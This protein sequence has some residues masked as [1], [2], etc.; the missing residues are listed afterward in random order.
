MCKIL[1]LNESIDGAEIVSS[2]CSTNH[3]HCWAGSFLYSASCRSR[4]LIL[5]YGPLL[6]DASEYI[7]YIF[8][9]NKL[10][11]VKIMLH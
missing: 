11:C 4:D 6:G 9:E 1:A 7:V 8:V 2:K 5:D 3:R 10:N